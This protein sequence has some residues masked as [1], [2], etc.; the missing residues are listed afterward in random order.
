MF[1]LHKYFFVDC[2]RCLGKKVSFDLWVSRFYHI[3]NIILKI[4]S[5]QPSMTP[6][7]LRTSRYGCKKMVPFTLFQERGL[8]LKWYGRIENN[9]S[10]TNTVYKKFIVYK[11]LKRRHCVICVHKLSFQIGIVA[12]LVTSS[13]LNAFHLR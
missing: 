7:T 5:F 1:F 13:V 2:S 3:V 9:S 4:D 8:E 10:E 11:I 12:F 6:Q